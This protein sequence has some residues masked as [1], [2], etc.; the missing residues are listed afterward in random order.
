[1]RKLNQITLIVTVLLALTATAQ[2]LKKPVTDNAV[3]E[4]RKLVEQEEQQRLVGPSDSRADIGTEEEI[5][6]PIH[7]SMA[8]T[9]ALVDAFVGNSVNPDGLD[10]DVT[11]KRIRA[12]LGK[13][14]ARE[15]EYSGVPYV[16]VSDAGGERSLLVGYELSTWRMG[17]S[18]VTIRAYKSDGHR[19]MLTAETGSKIDA[20][21]VGDSLF[22]RE[23]P[24]PVAGETWL[25]TWGAHA[26]SN[27]CGNWEMR[28]Y[29]YDGSKFKTVWSDNAW[30][31]SV[32]L[33]KAGFN[34]H[35]IDTNREAFGYYRTYE[36][37]LT[38]EGPKLIGSIS[39][40]E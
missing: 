32:V 21:L 16:F 7:E 8:K 10:R 23:V 4:T 33:T 6:K 19:F 11:E 31:V 27:Q 26:G 5:E 24:S 3:E 13:A 30:C 28:L 34:V 15:T 29:S 37:Q 12:I 2:T 20:E 17:D 9:D 38:P 40:P 39:D 35:H 18:E 25:L 14:D 22:M 36:Y 1:M